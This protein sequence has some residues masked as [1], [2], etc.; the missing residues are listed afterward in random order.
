MWDEAIKILEKQGP[1]SAL[2]NIYLT[3]QLL[4]RPGKIAD[5]L[6]LDAETILQDLGWNKR[7]RATQSDKLKKIYHLAFMLSCFRTRYEI[8]TKLRGHQN[9]VTFADEGH[10]W[11]IR[12]K[13][14]G[15]KTL[16]FRF[17][18]FY[19]RRSI[20]QV[21]VRDRTGSLGR[22]LSQPTKSK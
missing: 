16:F 5:K 15:E 2:F 17:C 6:T 19:T 21:M 4:A 18:Q 3:G 7:K 10:A 9:L 14:I 22:A 13:S 11:H 20:A 8:N 12:F 1:E